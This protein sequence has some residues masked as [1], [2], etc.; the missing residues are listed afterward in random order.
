MRHSSPACRLLRS[1]LPFFMVLVLAGCTVAPLSRLQ[2]HKQV[3]RKE[4][5]AIAETYRTA[6][7]RPT[8][9]NV[10]H[11]RDS[12]G[13]QVDTPDSGEAWRGGWW[14]PDQINVGIPY[15]WG[16]FDTPTSFQTKLHQGFAAG[17]L[18]TA[19]KRAGLETAVSR[20]A[21]GIDCSGFISRC[22]KLDRAYSTRELPS[23]CEPLP[24][25][26]HLQPGDI[27]NVSN[28]HVVLFIRWADARRTQLSVYEAGRHPVWKVCRRQIRRE[29][30]EKQ[31]ALPWRYRGMK[32]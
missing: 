8:Q 20:E 27:L 16:G 31:G 29:H 32:E 13:I 14:Q 7:W 10:R 2:T 26:D 30:L 28:G 25:Y 22:W 3:S 12:L 9:V 11:G 21:C 23:L 17:D 18:Y 19:E 4:A 1:Q 6:L 24:D 5:L 15:Q